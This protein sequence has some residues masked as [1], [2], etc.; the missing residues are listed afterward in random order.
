MISVN[1]DSGSINWAYHTV[2][3]SSECDCDWSAGA[4]VMKTSCGELIASM[5]KDGWSYAIDA[6]AGPACPLSGHSWQFPPTTKGCPFPPNT[7]PPSQT[8]AT[9]DHGDDDYRRPGAAWGD[10]F[11][12]RTGGESRV[13][14]GA[15]AGYARFHALNAC[16]TTEKDRVRWMADIPNSSGG[17]GAAGAATVTGGIV[18][19][20]TD[21]GHLIVL[22][23]PSVVPAAGSR[24]SSIDYT[25]AS[26]CTAHG[27][28]LVPIPKVLANVAIPDGGNLVAMRNEPVLAKGRVFVG[29]G[30]GHVY[31]LEP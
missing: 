6:A 12:V 20:G 21:Q 2:P 15:A 14:D 16:G 1:K 4:T 18:F 30:S 22:G 26:A 31:M 13:A 27:Y 19:I 23:D 17:D 24:C 29:T 5:Q 9:A 11:I 3:F 25:T 28:S 10:V 8:Q 7:C